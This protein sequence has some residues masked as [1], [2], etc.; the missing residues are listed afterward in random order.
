MGG[1]VLIKPLEDEQ[2]ELPQQ[3]NHAGPP[4]R[5]CLSA[6]RR[7]AQRHRQREDETFRILSKEMLVETCKMQLLYILYERKCYVLFNQKS[8]I[9]DETE[10]DWNQRIFEKNLN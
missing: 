9:Y 8:L 3:Q 4:L 1:P 10:I 7:H 2:T 5:L 6:Q